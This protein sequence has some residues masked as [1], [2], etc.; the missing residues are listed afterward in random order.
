MN[1]HIFTPYALE[2]N[3]FLFF[4]VFYNIINILTIKNDT[5]TNGKFKCVILKYYFYTLKS[6]TNI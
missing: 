3:Q 4:I 5:S 2:D 1:I 6:K